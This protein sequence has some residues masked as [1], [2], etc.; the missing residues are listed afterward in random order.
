M[1]ITLED[2]YLYI[3]EDIIRQLPRIK[4]N[5]DETILGTDDR[6]ILFILEGA[7]RFI[8]YQDGKRITSPFVFKK[9]NV[10][11]FNL[12]FSP[13]TNNWEFNSSQEGEAIIFSEDIVDK[14]IFSSTDSLK[15]FMK[16][17]IPVTE[18]AVNGF[19]ILAHGGAKA[20]LAYLLIQGAEN[21]RYYFER[22][23]D[24]TE[25]LGISKTMLY[26]ITKSL[27]DKRLIKKE[28]KYVIIL[29]EKG[30]EELYSDY[31]YL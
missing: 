29:D 24:F 6:Y 18:S 2:I 28:K 5:S 30:L 19:Y 20:Y 21:K 3:P 10:V 27:I 17:T 13:N 11:G 1:N 25:T 4:F 8:R 15:F 14:Y 7:G 12:L 31:L 22:Y 9:N 16:K 23:E 26:R